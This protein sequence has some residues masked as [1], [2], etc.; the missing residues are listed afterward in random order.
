MQSNHL[1]HLLVVVVICFKIEH[2][3]EIFEL[4]SHL[5]DPRYRFLFHQFRGFIFNS[6]GKTSKKTK[7]IFLQEKFPIEKPFPCNTKIGMSTKYPE[8]VHRLKP[9][10]KGKR[11]T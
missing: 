1:L 3:K 10:G 5:D 7:G 11:K 8:S 9:G 4:T 2:A 6:I